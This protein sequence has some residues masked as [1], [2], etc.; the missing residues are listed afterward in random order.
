MR[1]REFGALPPPANYVSGGE[2]RGGGWR[3][4]DCL[5]HDPPPPTP[6][7]H[8]LREWEEGSGLTTRAAD[9]N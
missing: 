2:G 6:P 9:V 4:W 1:C 7:H 3:V 5:T 8:S